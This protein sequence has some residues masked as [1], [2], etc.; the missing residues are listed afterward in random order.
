MRRGEHRVAAGFL[1]AVILLLGLGALV[2]LL[3]EPHLEGRNANATVW[4][5]Y[6]HDPFLAYAC[7]ASLSFFGALYQGFRVLGQIRQGRVI[8]PVAVARLQSLKRCALAMIGFALGGEVFLFLGSFGES[9]DRA[10][11]V[12]MGGLIILA[13]L[14]MAAAAS[15]SERVV[16]DAIEGVAVSS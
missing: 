8:T 5:V 11:G 2:F 4:Q 12:A 14:V 6:F 15:V 7:I 9:D 13:A 16:R 3:W 10:G 1:Q